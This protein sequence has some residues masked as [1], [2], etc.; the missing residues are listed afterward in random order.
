MDIPTGHGAKPYGWGADGP[1]NKRP[2]VPMERIPPSPVPGAHGRIERQSPTTQKRKKLETPKLTP[3]FGTVQPPSGVSGLI[4]LFAYRIPQHK[5]RR[6]MLLIAADKVDVF[7]YRLQK[8]G[9][10]L[11]FG[12][13]ATAGILL[14]RRFVRD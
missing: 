7:G 2:G 3:V 11:L 5:A 4:R 12:G 9:V 14:F 6:W 8:A 13:V 1:M 10:P